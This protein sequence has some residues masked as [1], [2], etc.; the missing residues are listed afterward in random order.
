MAPE[1]GTLAAPRFEV[2]PD[3]LKLPIGVAFGE[4][5][6][7]KTDSKDRLYVFSRR[8]HQV[9]V[10]SP[11]GD[12]LY[13]WGAG[14]F[15]KPHGL[16][17][18]K[19]D[20]VFL[21]DV[22]DHT[23]RKFT[24]EGKLLLTIGTAHQPSDTG[25]EFQKSPVQ[26][27]AGP[28]NMVTH[29]IEAPDGRLLVTDGYGNARVHEF[30]SDG[31]LI[32][33]WGEPGHAPGQFNLPHGLALTPDNRL[34]VCDRENSRIQ[35]FSD[36]GQLLDVWSGFN[37]P[38]NVLI[39]DGLAYVTE[40]GFHANRYGGEHFIYMADPPPGHTPEAQISICTLD[41]T[42]LARLG[43]ENVACPGNVIAPHG[44]AIDSRGDLYVGETPTDGGASRLH[45]GA[46]LPTVQKFRRLT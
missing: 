5:P 41:G 34:L 40:I 2:I 28:F 23:I 12:F 36:S 33:S 26:R 20:N 13:S 18:D 19:Q 7:L 9:S 3:W 14:L 16:Y 15:T 17:I 35:V 1:A 21:V 45:P 32:R 39:R 38:N 8:P 31:T 44:L 10:F 24:P 22:G 46:T 43:A 4:V 25:L 37:R 30:T 27:A 11:D 42:I 29:L 6:D